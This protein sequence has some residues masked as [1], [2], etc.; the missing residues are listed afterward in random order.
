MA[1]HH[2]Y[3]RLLPAL[4][5]AAGLLA[6]HAAAAQAAA[7]GGELSHSTEWSGDP[8]RP[9]TNAYELAQPGQSSEGELQLGGLLLQDVYGHRPLP[10]AKL[11]SGNILPAQADGKALAP[12]LVA[13]SKE[14]FAGVLFQGTIGTTPAM[15]IG[16]FSTSQAPEGAL[17]RAVGYI[18]NN[19]NGCF[20]VANNYIVNNVNGNPTFTSIWGVYWYMYNA[21][22]W[23]TWE[24]V[25]PGSANA[26]LMYDTAHDPTTTDIVYGWMAKLPASNETTGWYKLDMNTPTFT[27]ISQPQIEVRGVAASTDGKYFAIAADGKVYTVE[28][29]TG[30]FTEL[31][32]SGAVSQYR[33]TAAY[34]QLSDMI[35]YVTVNDEGSSLYCINPA[36][37]AGTK[38]YD[39]PQLLQLTGL[40]FGPRQAPDGAPATPENVTINFK[41]DA[42][43]GAIEFDVPELT[44]DNE[45]G[46]GRVK[47]T[48]RMQWTADPATGRT[49]YQDYTGSA[50][51]GSHVAEYITLPEGRKYTITVR[52]SNEV[53][54]GP[55]SEG[56]I[57]Y[58]GPD[59]PNTPYSFKGVYEDGKWKL[60][61]D[62]HSA[63]GVNGGD[64][65]PNA[66][67]YLLTFMPEGRQVLTEGGATSYE[68]EMAEPDEFGQYYWICQAKT[69]YSTASN[70]RSTAKVGLGK[71]YPYWKEDFSS[72][73]NSTKADAV[74][75]Y[76]VLELAEKKSDWSWVSPKWINHA[77][78]RGVDADSYFILPKVYLYGG[79]YYTFN[80]SAGKY[81]TAYGNP[82]FRVVMGSSPTEEGLNEKVL[83]DRTT[84]TTVA[85]YENRGE[86]GDQYSVTFMPE[87]DGVYYIAIHH[88]N[89]YLG[90][91][92]GNAGL[93]NLRISDLEITS[94]IIPNAPEQVKNL[95]AEADVDGAQKV[96]VSFTCP[97][98]NMAG[99]ALMG[100][101]RAEIKR[102]DIMVAD[103]P[104]T[105]STFK[106]ID[107]D[108]EMG[109][110]SYT[111]TPYN[112]DGAGNPLTT[113]CF[114]GMAAP[115]DV[116]ELTAV[117][118]EVK[119]TVY[120]SWT[121]A[122]KDINGK[123]L[124]NVRY[125]L[126]RN[127]GGETEIVSENLTAC[128]YTDKVTNGQ[129]IQAIY[130]VKAV[131]DEGISAGWAASKTLL[132]GN[133]YD[134]PYI[135]SLKDGKL[136][137]LLIPETSN[138]YGS[139]QLFYDTDFSDL[140]SADRDNGFLGFCSQVSGSQGA[141]TTGRI[142]IPSEMEN[143]V[144]SFYY[145]L[146]PNGTNRIQALIRTDDNPTYE[147]LAFFTAGD[148]RKGWQVGAVDMTPYLGRTVQL[149][150][151]C[152]TV[153]H[154][155]TLLDRLEV[156]SMPNAD[157]NN[158]T[159]SATAKAELNGEV[160]ISVG[161]MN[162]A[163]KPAKD[164][165]VLILR[166]GEQI[167]QLTG[168]SID[169][170]ERA[171]LTYTDT[172]PQT[173]GDQL[174]YEAVVEIEGD[175]NEADNKTME[176]AVVTVIKPEL[177]LATNLSGNRLSENEVE[178]AWI[179]P[180]MDQR[181]LETVTEGFEGLKTGDTEVK[182]W[183][184]LDR[185][186]RSIGFG[187]SSNINFP[188]LVNNE[189]AAPWLAVNTTEN[190]CDAAHGGDVFMGAC[191]LVDRS[192]NDDWLISPE[193]S[194][195]A[196][197][198]SVWARSYTN[199]YGG[200]RIEILYS[201]TGREVTNFVSAY[202]YPYFPTAWTE[203]KVALPEGAKYFAIR[204][205]SIYQIMLC[206]DDVTYS[207]A[208]AS[209]KPMVV[210]GYNVWRDGVKVNDSIVTD[211]YYKD[212]VPA[213]D[214]YTYQVTAVYDL[215]E[216]AASDKATVD[217]YVN[218]IDD[219]AQSEAT[220][221][222]NNLTI[223]VS[224]AE[225]MHVD[226]YS[227]DGKSVYAGT[228]N[229]AVNVAP[230]VYV[231]AVG[232]KIVKVI[233][234]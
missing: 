126:V 176:P 227:V 80:F 183:L 103:V 157:I 132:L 221:T 39:F 187:G 70:T 107:S 159:I 108:P 10:Q 146:M 222:V 192:E 51:Y 99:T 9:Q 37:G 219:M 100:M 172:V 47:Y 115:A 75:G 117:E 209:F 12:N 193:L 134:A 213:N 158:V 46:E 224:N 139:W 50:T 114:V 14:A 123:N 124:K 77:Y 89:K 223:C 15:Y 109:T 194:G 82:E 135:E 42:L 163:I 212:I 181:P 66:V 43:S 208:G 200:D 128:D 54:D 160:N 175:A 91:S 48:V 220:V 137:T 61:W 218:S 5:G 13:R 53:G 68:E 204:C 179:E 229:A 152:T 205:T 148:A 177:P 2:L 169:I 210:K 55:W 131:T 94:P 173:A 90:I 211:T 171:L 76:S 104:L 125:V 120:L 198:V 26:Y 38:V 25:S 29:A 116:A 232:N 225:G 88:C 106:W 230:G 81:G 72:Y 178:L 168:D 97:R 19:I 226:I 31:G 188:E 36:T 73:T 49:D 62:A 180:D 136:M 167:A 65:D 83:I 93:Y 86:T 140:K 59:Q 189:S 121:P 45:E 87:K 174:K 28:K 195:K 196:Q 22:T 207:P 92:S 74:A 111:V 199:F 32:N 105:G 129:Q 40:Y 202:E 164:Y 156:R 69:D 151:V 186:G 154:T 214:A 24:S 64:I 119:G 18:N 130:G 58:I 16:K 7:A 1:K 165:K 142:K 57:K 161:L 216:S 191:Y 122:T 84:A 78:Y 79:R 184:N 155:Y 234:G 162:A 233:A 8:A 101:T 35:Y 166:D 71:I 143:P 56:I 30:V 20:N 153:S 17:D 113:T 149:T 11:P 141:L 41:P 33:T 3:R 102:G 95:V 185:D 228:G 215:G 110:N 6:T 217:T 197:T 52:C 127:L 118:T 44:Y 27:L 4:L 23:S 201:T 96:T 85:G 170:C 203:V 63:T 67:K 190:N 21:N 60:T 133:A 145:F 34:D 147:S 138:S 98:A 112:N 231:V 206:V 144:F 150:L 182:G